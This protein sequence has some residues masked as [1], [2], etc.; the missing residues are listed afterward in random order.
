MRGG[1]QKSLLI[2][3][4]GSR[5]SA[6]FSHCCHSCA[7][8][9]SC[10]GGNEV[11][12]Y[13]QANATAT[14]PS[15]RSSTSRLACSTQRCGVEHG[16]ASRRHSSRT[17]TRWPVRDRWSPLPASEP[18]SFSTSVAASEALPAGGSARRS[19]GSSGSEVTSASE[20]TY[21]APSIDW[22]SES[23]EG[24]SESWDDESEEKSRSVVGGR[25]RRAGSWIQRR[26]I[27]T[28]YIRKV[29]SRG[30]LTCDWFS[31]EHASDAGGMRAH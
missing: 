12:C 8:L 18:E 6:P 3:L 7:S 21:D 11:A 17:A 24:R 4:T 23:D 25:E 26:H 31:I 19:A 1:K 28:Q 15:A 16:A 20:R 22:T 5:R 30:V 9:A 10:P 14:I 27:R 29:V 2:Y 13:A